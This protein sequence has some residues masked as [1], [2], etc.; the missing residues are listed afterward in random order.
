[1]NEKFPLD[2]VMIAGKVVH[3]V[4]GTV[5]D[6]CTWNCEPV[7]ALHWSDMLLPVRV[8]L[9]IIG[10]GMVVPGGSVP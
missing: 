9:P 1:M 3:E 10:R 5:G 6:H 7:A 2:E 4:V 8:K